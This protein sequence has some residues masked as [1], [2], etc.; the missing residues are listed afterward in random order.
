[1]H[2]PMIVHTHVFI[3]SINLYKLYKHNL[4]NLSFCMSV[5]IRYHK[6]SQSSK[7]TPTRDHAAANVQAFPSKKHLA[8]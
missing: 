7:I 4:G 5:V 3:Q 6:I 2:A 1:M 8:P